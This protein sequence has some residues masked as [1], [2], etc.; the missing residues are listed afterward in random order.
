M[1]TW[2][3]VRGGGIGPDKR[4]RSER[5][6]A[7]H[8]RV[9]YEHPVTTSLFVD[10]LRLAETSRGSAAE[11]VRRIRDEVM[12]ASTAAHTAAHEAANLHNQLA[13]SSFHRAP[14]RTHHAILFRKVCHPRP[15][16]PG[17]QGLRDFFTRFQGPRLLAP[18]EVP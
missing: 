14:P 5:G 6:L 11:E 13:V 12:G 2:H 17:E 9:F 18:W 8:A 4:C 16:H 10:I 1:H 7:C 15:K 3:P